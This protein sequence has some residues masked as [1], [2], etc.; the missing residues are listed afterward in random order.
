MGGAISKT[1]EKVLIIEMLLLET[2]KTGDLDHIKRALHL[3]REIKIQ[4][5]K[6]YKL[7]VKVS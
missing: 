4:I 3:F 2:L 7:E 1:K 5:C 6:E